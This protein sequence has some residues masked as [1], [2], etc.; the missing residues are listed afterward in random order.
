MKKNNFNKNRHKTGSPRQ[1]E[2]GNNRN[3]RQ[4][5]TSRTETT[6]R[7]PASN[8]RV[9][10]TAE[11]KKK[12]FSRVKLSIAVVVSLIMIGVFIIVNNNIDKKKAQKCIPV[13]NV[14]HLIGVENMEIKDGV[15]KLSGYCFKNGIDTVETKQFAQ[16][17]VILMNMDD[18]NEKYF[19]KSSITRHEKLNE[20]FPLKFTDYVN[21]GFEAEIK[22]SKLD[23]DSKN[24]EIL[25]SKMDYAWDADGFCQTGIRSGYFIIKGELVKNK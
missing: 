24:Y 14:D 5:Q 13:D 3:P 12:S 15:L 22:T 11:I 23:L 7:Q 25:F 10:T 19:M 16:V 8:I 4:T 18:Q 2:A 9:V 1:N 6:P 17:M 21:G 20:M